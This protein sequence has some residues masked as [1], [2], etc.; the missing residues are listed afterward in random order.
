MFFFPL[1]IA[2]KGFELPL[3]GKMRFKNT[4]LNIYKVCFKQYSHK[5]NIPFAL[6]KK[7]PYS[8]LFSLKKINFRSRN[9]KLQCCINDGL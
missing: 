8:K 4:D 5:L 9:K 3:L 7:L 1:A 2:N 6:G